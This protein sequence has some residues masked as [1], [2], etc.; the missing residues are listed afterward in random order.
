MKIY[1]A[2]FR[3]SS[4]T[5]FTTCSMFHVPLHTYLHLITKKQYSLLVKNMYYDGVVSAPRFKG[6]FLKYR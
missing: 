4:C 2:A 5:V 6:V 1:A 3:H